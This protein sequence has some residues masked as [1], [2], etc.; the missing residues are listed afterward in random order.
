MYG[1]KN[2][3]INR[4]TRYRPRRTARKYTK[5][6]RQL[7]RSRI[8]GTPSGMTAQKV[9]KLRYND[10]AVIP[11]TTG[12][13]GYNTFRCNSCY[14]PNA[15]LGGH[16]PMGFDIW[17]Q[18]Y[19]HY[20]VLGS[21]ITVKAVGMSSQGAPTYCGVIRTD[22]VTFPHTSPNYVIE[23]GFK[24]RILYN[25]R[26]PTTYSLNY[27]AKKFFQV[28]NV[29]DNTARLGAQVTTNPVEEA[30]F[31]VWQ[32]PMDVSTSQTITFD[33]TVEYIVLFSEPKKGVIS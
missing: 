19:N 24:T 30:Y 10:T 4:K 3:K 26:L 7:T 8:Q 16:Q 31:H 21:K 27:S 25:P 9:V 6:P 29:K 33:V 14:D 18:M 28:T 1:K 23:E 15:T 13:I 11:S 5:I 2:Y 12:N 22:V 32:V 20:T 17:T